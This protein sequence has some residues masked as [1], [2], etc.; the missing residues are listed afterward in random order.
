MDLHT[1]NE[2]RNVSVASPTVPAIGSAF[3][4]LTPSCVH[5]RGIYAFLS[6]FFN[7]LPH[8]RCLPHALSPARASSSFPDLLRRWQKRWWPD[9]APVVL[10]SSSRPA[11]RPRSG[12]ELRRPLCSRPQL[13]R[14][15][16]PSRPPPSAATSFLRDL[17][18][19]RNRGRRVA[20]VALSSSRGD[21]ELLGDGGRGAKCDNPPGKI[22]Y[23]RL[24][25]STLVIKQ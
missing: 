9:P 8:N 11:R 23:Y 5:S 22:T 16:H 14:G 3:C 18:R 6:H 4:S 24:N 1:Q 12:G 20:P 17:A 19:K 25:Q 21:S 13:S 15:C 2:E 7:V 10:C